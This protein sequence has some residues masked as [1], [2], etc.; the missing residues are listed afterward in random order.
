MV[1]IILEPGTK[2]N[3]AKCLREAVETV[4]GKQ[5]SQDG[6][7]NMK[8]VELGVRC[9]LCIMMLLGTESVGKIGSYL[10]LLTED[11]GVSLVGQVVLYYEKLITTHEVQLVEGICRREFLVSEIREGDFEAGA[12]TRLGKVRLTEGS[13]K[14][15][16]D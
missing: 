4:I 14:K 6:T 1:L 15:V 11:E 16:V 10:K 8:A 9:I 5:R 13:L 3:L 12:F 7:N 2:S